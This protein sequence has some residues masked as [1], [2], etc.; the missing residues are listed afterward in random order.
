MARQAARPSSGTTDGG[1]WPGTC[2][3]GGV[4]ER[5]CDARR[6]DC[7]GRLPLAVE[8]PFLWAM[9]CDAHPFFE[10]WKGFGMLKSTNECLPDI[11]GWRRRCASL[12]LRRQTFPGRCVA[13]GE[14][15]NAR[16]R[17][18]IMKV[19]TMLS[20]KTLAISCLPPSWL[21]MAICLATW[22]DV[23]RRRPPLPMNRSIAASTGTGR[24]KR[25]SLKESK[26]CSIVL[27]RNVWLQQG[28]PKVRC[29]K[30]T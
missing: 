26:P 1:S 5:L 12:M 21:W 9:V 10:A 19:P 3:P 25:V 23:K 6:A 24:W 13:T 22:T 18:S 27:S 20:S 15:G 30:R 14:T 16:R 29:K 7:C 2:Q 4:C 28:T 17:T 11:A 8:R